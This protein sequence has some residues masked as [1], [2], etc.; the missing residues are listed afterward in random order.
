MSKYLICIFIS[1][2]TPQGAKDVYERLCETSAIETYGK[3]KEIYFTSDPNDNYTHAIIM[4]TAMPRLKNIPKKNVLGLAFEPPHF[5]GLTN[6]FVHYAIQN[7]GTYFI[8][9]TMGLPAPFTEHYGYMWHMPLLKER[10]VKRPNMMSIM[11]SMKQQAPGH[12]YRHALVQRIL[13]TDLPIDIYGNGSKLYGNNDSR[14][15]GEFKETEPFLPYHFHIAIENFQLNHY[16]SEKIVNPLLAGTTPI[17]C[18]CKN[19]DSYFPNMVIKLTGD[20]DN[21]LNLFVDIFNNFGLYRKTVDIDYVKNRINLV[22]HIPKLFE[23]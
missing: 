18:G 9:E 3:D 6:E 1:F 13:A 14:L 2:G 16:F 12:K 10:P 23:S 11:V 7:I 19:I 5:L 22:K 4:N 15:K 17:Y 8:G 20:V 21:D